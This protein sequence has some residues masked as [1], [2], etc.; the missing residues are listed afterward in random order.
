[1][2]LKPKKLE[3]LYDIN[4]NIWLEKKVLLIFP[5]KIKWA[6]WWSAFKWGDGSPF[7]STSKIILRLKID[8]MV[9]RWYLTCSLP[10]WLRPLFITKYQWQWAFV[11]QMRA[12][13]HIWRPHSPH[14]QWPRSSCVVSGSVMTQVGWTP[15]N[16]LWQHI[17]RLIFRNGQ[18]HNPH[19]PWHASSPL[20]H[21]SDTS[22]SA[23][24]Q[25]HSFILLSFI[26][27][28]LTEELQGN[29]VEWLKSVALALIWSRLAV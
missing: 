15:R 29:T 6:L 8:H 26:C 3:R 23:R 1:M 9:W 14:L 2:W 7:H 13:C 27:L 19:F 11:P 18:F 25:N 10:D 5:L 22:I 16:K 28:S 12:K 4:L 21:R 24:A 20:S 17:P